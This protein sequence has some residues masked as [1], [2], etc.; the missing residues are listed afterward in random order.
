MK[1][2]SKFFYLPIVL[3]SAC[4][5]VPSSGDV[6]DSISELFSE[7]K[8]IS[9][10][11]KKTNGRA[12]ENGNYLVNAEIELKLEPLQENTDLWEKFLKNSDIYP[13]IKQKHDEELVDF[14]N[15]Y[16]AFQKAYS[17]K[18]YASLEEDRANFELHEQEYDK[19]KEEE[20]GIRLRQYQELEKMGFERGNFDSSGQST[21]R[22]EGVNFDKNCK[23]KKNRM[24]LDLTWKM[25]KV[26]SGDFKESAEIMAKG[27]TNTFV[28]DL[29][30]MKTE[31]GWQLKR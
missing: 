30:M 11:A 21:A 29:E 10:D 3:L 28:V 19:L 4:S 22:S 18:K 13:Q 15:R 26:A 12:L 20:N 5:D 16:D 23:T 14:M 8:S 7:C 2:K 1:L 31:N 24:A 17:A 25:L 9:V 6:N 27:T